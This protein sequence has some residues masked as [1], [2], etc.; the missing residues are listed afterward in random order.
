MF[1]IRKINGV[2][3]A[4]VLLFIFLPILAFHFS[5]L[6]GLIPYDIVWGGKLSDYNQMLVFESLSIS[7]NLYLVYILFSRIKLV[8]WILG[9]VL[10]KVS[11]WFFTILFALNTIGNLLAETS[12][13]TIVFTPLTLIASVMIAFLAMEKDDQL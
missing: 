1:S 3:V 12:F 10:R 13:E 5:I 11:L 4:K 9:N 6:F 2:F 8:P 7:L